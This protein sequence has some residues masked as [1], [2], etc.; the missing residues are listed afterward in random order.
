[1]LNADRGIGFRVRHSLWAGVVAAGSSYGELPSRE[2]RLSPS[3][4]R[5]DAFGRAER[6]VRFESSC[7]DARADTWEHYCSLE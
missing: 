6:A 1:V 2:S 7:T 4:A 5:A 3:L